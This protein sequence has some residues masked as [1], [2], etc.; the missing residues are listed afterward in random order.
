ME[1]KITIRRVEHKDNAD[2]ENLIRS[3][4]VEFNANH[5]GTAWADL[6]LGQLSEIYNSDGNS[7]W[8]AVDKKG[9][10]IAGVGIGKIADVKDV[11]ELQ[12]MYCLPEIFL[13]ISLVNIS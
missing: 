9:E 10:I 4:L 3:C 13:K 11:C 8:V 12:K 1:G 5:D 6:F 2:V 7:Y